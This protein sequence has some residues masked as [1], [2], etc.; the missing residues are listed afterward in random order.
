MFHTYT[1][2][3]SLSLTLSLSLSLS[4]FFASNVASR[5]GVRRQHVERLHHPSSGHHGLQLLRLTYRAQGLGR[6]GRPE[7]NLQLD[8]CVIRHGMDDH[9]LDS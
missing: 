1:L 5:E 6:R 8:G 9:A 3:H 7:R 4:H 2:T